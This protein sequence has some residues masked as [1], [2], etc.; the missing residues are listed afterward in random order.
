M[1]FSLAIPVMAVPAKNNPNQ[2]FGEPNTKTTYDLPWGYYDDDFSIYLENGII[3]GFSIPVGKL[4]YIPIS[5]TNDTNR[6]C[7]Q[8][9]IWINDELVAFWGSVGKGETVK[10]V[11]EVD[12]SEVCKYMYFVEIWT[13]KDNLNYKDCGVG[14]AVIN[15][16]VPDNEIEIPGG[17]KAAVLLRGLSTA[18]IIDGLKIVGNDM[19]LTIGEFEL[20]LAKGVKNLNQSGEV[21]LGDGYFLIFDIAGNGKNIKTFEIIK[22]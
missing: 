3:P 15:V 14:A 10:Y 9:S 19:I 2:D 4:I 6:A 18:E 21:A 12:T 1:I 5:I 13:R 22:K 16:F 20:I 11:I 17:E 8:L 7:P